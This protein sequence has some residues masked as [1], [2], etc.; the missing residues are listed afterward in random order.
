M[1]LTIKLE[2]NNSQMLKL[3]NY[4]V[5]IGYHLINMEINKENNHRIVI[6]FNDKFTINTIKYEGMALTLGG[7][8]DED[9]EVF[10][11][12]IWELHKDI[13]REI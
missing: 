6:L 12:K 2:L 8:A 3:T 1:Q 10:I 5:R 7:K 13:I 4:F 9:F 11:D